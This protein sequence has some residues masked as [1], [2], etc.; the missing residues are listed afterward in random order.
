MDTLTEYLN[1]AKDHPERFVNPSEGGFTI[2]LQE[3]EI[4]EVETYMAQKL[5]AKKLPTEWSKVGI[6]CQ[7]QY[8]M[9]LRD[10][11]RFPGGALGTYIRFIGKADSTASVIILPLFQKQI[12]LVRRFSHATRTYHLEIPQ[13][14]G[15]K[16]LSSEENACGELKKE[17]GAFASRLIVIGELDEGPGLAG[18]NTQ[19]FYAEIASF[20]DVDL[21]EGISGAL[22]VSVPEFEQMIRDSEITDAFTLIAYLRAKL[23]NLI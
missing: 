22:L 5:G 20:G 13:G 3:D 23:H 4:H 1:F 12:L 14:Y 10:A 2:L 17:I 6:V 15:T 8:G 9:I 16:G 19:I 21:R 7:D 11:V 18:N